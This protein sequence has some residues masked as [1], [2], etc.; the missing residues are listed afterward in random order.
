MFCTKCGTKFEE[1]NENCIQCGEVVQKHETTPAPAVGNQ[2]ITV[3]LPPVKL[4][5]KGQ[6]KSFLNFETLITPVIMKALYIIGSIAIILSMLFMMFSDGIAQ[7]FL[8]LIAGI[9]GLV[10]Y[11]IFCEQILLFFTMNQKLG[12]IRDNTK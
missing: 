9:V 1:G 8:G 10:A 3:T 11:R 12:D 4:P 7:F 5:D 6:F 2:G